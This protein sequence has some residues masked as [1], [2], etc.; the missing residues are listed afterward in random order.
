[1]FPAQEENKRENRDADRDCDGFPIG[2][3]LPIFFCLPDFQAF[4]LALLVIIGAR[5]LSESLNRIVF[6]EPQGPG[7]GPDKASREHLIG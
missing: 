1:L 3:A 2:F 5:R 6:I 7:I 4:P